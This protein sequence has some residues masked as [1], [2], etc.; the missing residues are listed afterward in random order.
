MTGKYF[1]DT[2]ILVYSIDSNYPKRK[3]Q[4]RQLISKL[5]KENSGVISTQVFQEF[6]YASVK[7][8]HADSIKVKNLLKYFEKFEVVQINLP[9]IYEAID[10]SLTNK[11]SFWDALIV[12]SAEYSSC[13]KIYSE[14]LN[15][16]QVIRGLEII[17]PFAN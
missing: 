12:V 8:L 17:N 9:L 15:N 13:S 11:I 3:E 6:Y 5:L 7:K 1:I 14:D 4:S 16:S 2:N 10:C